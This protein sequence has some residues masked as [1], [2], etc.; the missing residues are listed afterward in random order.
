L[1]VGGIIFKRSGTRG[2]I[3]LVERGHE[4]LKGFWSLPG[5]LVETGERLEEA[6][7]REILE[8]TGLRVQPLRLFEIF[9]RIMRDPRGR[10]E[11]HY[12]LADYVCKVL[13]GTL[14]AGD[15]VSRAVWARRSDLGKYRLTEGTREVIE[16]VFAL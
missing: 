3:L 5:G 16:R 9:E 15:D 14:R 13:G 2:P 7:Q 11:Y 6:V 10:A 4:P 8:E 1:G 12:V